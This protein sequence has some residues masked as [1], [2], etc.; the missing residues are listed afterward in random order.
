MTRTLVL[1]ANILIRAVLGNQV[2]QL[3]AQYHRPVRFVAPEACFADAH[4]YL[5]SLMIEKV[6]PTTTEVIN[7]LLV[8]VEPI[9]TPILLPF[10][11]SARK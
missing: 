1:D 2:F 8:W 11:M 10:E 6:R 3:L 5:P 7:R 9:E 4:K